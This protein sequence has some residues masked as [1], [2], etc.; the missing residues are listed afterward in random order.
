MSLGAVLRWFPGLLLALIWVLS[1]WLGLAIFAGGQGVFV[2]KSGLYCVAPAAV[3][4]GVGSDVFRI[5]PEWISPEWMSNTVI[6]RW[7]P[8]RVL[9]TNAFGPTAT[10]I[11]IPLWLPTTI[12]AC[13]A[14]IR[15][16]LQRRRV[17]KCPACGYDLRATPD[18]C[19]ECGLIIK[20]RIENSTTKGP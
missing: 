19:P 10:I 5:E 11:V 13:F 18:R 9:T 6:E 4:K 1:H 3:P 8:V 12:F 20:D 14:L 16:P 15:L 7:K 2:A 17:G